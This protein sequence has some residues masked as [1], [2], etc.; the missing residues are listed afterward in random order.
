[1]RGHSQN[2]ADT[3]RAEVHG[4]GLVHATLAGD[5]I[6]PF[7]AVRVPVHLANAAWS[8]RDDSRRDFRRRQKVFR[9]RL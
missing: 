8:D 5:P 6:L 9:V 1:M 2:E 3:V 7:A 4:A